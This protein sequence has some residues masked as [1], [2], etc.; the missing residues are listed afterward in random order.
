MRAV[1]IGD[2]VRLT[3][4]HRDLGAEDP[5]T[6]WVLALVAQAQAWPPDALWDQELAA[7]AARTTLAPPADV[8]AAW[9][10]A[11]DLRSLAAALGVPWEVA[12]ARLLD[13]DVSVAFSAAG[14]PG[15]ARGP[16]R[17]DARR[18]ARCRR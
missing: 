2:A 3:A 18:R 4:E 8:V 14:T 6:L 7:R 1:V 12:L 16:R 17:R 9:S 13:R 11:E 5:D 15:L 10:R